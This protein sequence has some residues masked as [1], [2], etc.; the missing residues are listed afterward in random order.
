MSDTSPSVAKDSPPATEAGFPLRLTPWRW[1]ASLLV[2]AVAAWAALNF[3]PIHFDFPPEL[4][5]VD[6]YHPIEM[7]REAAAKEVEL[8][9]KNSL[10]E[11]GLAGLCFGA[12]TLL[13]PPRVDFRRRLILGTAALAFGI[14]C[15]LLATALG[16]AVRGY[17][18]SGAGLTMLDENNRKMMADIV[19]YALTSV[20]L[21]LPVAPAVL[22]S[23]ERQK[24]QKVLAVPLAGVATGLL[25]P[26]IASFMLPAAPTHTF[27]PEGLGLTALWL[28]LLAGLV[29]L[30]TSLTDSRQGADR[31]VADTAEGAA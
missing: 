29:F 22:A 31:A 17:F 4:Y 23:G 3:N 19:V 8:Y 14:A 18:D 9:W 26:L 12:V 5:G 13:S 25:L 28:A 20:L 7:Q 10:A 1:G 30:F 2:A 16:T 21:V 6:Q 24:G 15:G 27:P 11:L